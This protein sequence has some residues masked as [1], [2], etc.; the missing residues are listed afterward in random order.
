MENK[1]TGIFIIMIVIMFNSFAVAGNSYTGQWDSNIYN[2]LDHPK[3][4]ALRVEVLDSETRLPLEDALVFFKGT[5][6]TE[7]RTS[8]HSDGEQRAQEKEFELSTRT[9]KD[10][11]AIVALAWQKEYPWRY[12]TDE[13]EKVQLIE[14]LYRGYHFV[15]QG[16]PFKRF[17]DIGQNK[18]S[19]SQEPRFF[20]LF[21]KTWAKECSRSDVK[22]CTLKFKKNFSDLNNNKST[23]SEFFEK[24]RNK[25]WGI[26]YDRPIN[27]TQWEDKDQRLCGPY[28]IYTTK[29]YMDRII[30][31]N[32]QRRRDQKHSNNAIPSKPVEP[33]IETNNRS[34]KRT[35]RDDSRAIP[36]SRWQTG[37]LESL[38]WGM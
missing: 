30:K 7:E 29:I 32:D 35:S 14:V 24:I 38:D 27:R 34:T 26:V 5:Y 1:M 3:T 8:R 11:V 6:M 25:D 9:G 21:E 37:F 10:G 15:E 13:I 20:D 2:L 36:R 23:H 33:K 31:D 4:V 12:G 18:N 17:L 22:F 28:L 19:D 16:I